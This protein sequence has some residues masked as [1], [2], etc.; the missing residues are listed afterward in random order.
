MSRLFDRIVSRGPSPEGK[1]SAQMV[2]ASPHSAV[3]EVI[4]LTSSLIVADEVAEYWAANL[5]GDGLLDVADL[6]NLAPVLQPTFVE[7]KWPYAYLPD[8]HHASLKT[9]RE[10]GYHLRRVGVLLHYEDLWE[11]ETKNPLENS[12]FLSELADKAEDARWLLNTEIFLELAGEGKP[13]GPVSNHYIA[14]RADGT[15]CEHEEAF[16]VKS[17][18]FDRTST[19]GYFEGDRE[20]KDGRHYQLMT[21]LDPALLAICFAHCKNVDLEPQEPPEKLSR[22]H[23][24]KHGKALS[25]YHV[26]QIDPARKLLESEGDIQRS[27]IKKALHLTRGHFRTY[28]PDKPLFG[29][30]TGTVWVPQHMRGSKHHG[31][32]KK[33]YAV[34]QPHHGT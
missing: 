25:R 32:V 17:V 33:D 4:E 20:S 30:Y 3:F 12:E 29:K 27:G 22:K 18:L 7:Y 11:K 9:D 23:E 2:G 34:K 31:E 19:G 24:R 21:A 8:E 16:P 13:R 14:L 15:V 5:A 6:P 10:H 26:L 1:L 28:T